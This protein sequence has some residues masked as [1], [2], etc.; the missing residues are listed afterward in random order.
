MAA[1]NLIRTLSIRRRS[2]TVSLMTMTTIQSLKKLIS[3]EGQKIPIQVRK[4][5]SAPGRYQIV[6]GHR[7]WRACRDLGIKIKAISLELSDSELVV[8]QG[9]ENAARQELSWDRARPVCLENG[10]G[11][12]KG[13]RYSRGS[14]R[15]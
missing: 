3:D 2:P 8:A 11:G 6:Y 15:G 14:W 5:P 7:R 10:A 4:H 1:W 12:D 9:I 13:A